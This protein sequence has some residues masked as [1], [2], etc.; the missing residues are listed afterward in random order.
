M[1]DVSGC[2][3]FGFVRILTRWWQSGDEDEEG[4]K[5]GV[6][7]SIDGYFD[8]DIDWSTLEWLK[9]S[10]TRNAYM[11]ILTE[12]NRKRPNSPLS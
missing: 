1:L 10:A 2:L 7:S 12:I 3:N 4:Q 9:A 6:A 11:L 5:G 8:T